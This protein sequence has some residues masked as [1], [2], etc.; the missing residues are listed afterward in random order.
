MVDNNIKV[1]LSSDQTSCHA[2]Y[3]G[4]YTPY[5]ISF[6]E[7]RELVAYD[8][9][10]FRELVDESLKKQIELIKIMDDRGTSFWDYGNSFLKAVYDAGDI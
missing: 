2:V 4:G 6:E 3:E 9:M 5:Q 8:N 1:E 7:S 10:K